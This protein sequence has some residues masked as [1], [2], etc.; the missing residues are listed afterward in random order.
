V[1]PGIRVLPES[2]SSVAGRRPEVTPRGGARPLDD[3]DEAREPAEQR[4]HNAAVYS[5]LVALR[6]EM[7]L[8]DSCDPPAPHD[9]SD[10]SNPANPANPANPSDPR[11]P[12]DSH[13]HS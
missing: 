1:P 9:P 11:H 6:E 12:A 8:Y 10:A 5:E 3:P 4:A 2:G 13:G 7:G